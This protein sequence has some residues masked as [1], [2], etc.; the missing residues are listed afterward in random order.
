MVKKGKMDKIIKIFFCLVVFIMFSCTKNEEFQDVN[1]GTNKITNLKNYKLKY[2][3]VNDSISNI[4]G[5]NKECIIKGYLLY[6]KKY[7]EWHVVMA[8]DS[9]ERII[10]IDFL[11]FKN[12]EFVNQYRLYDDN[13]KID[14]KRS[15]FYKN[16]FD[17]KLYQIHFNLPY[18][19]V[20]KTHNSKFT[21]FIVSKGNIIE[22]KTFNSKSDISKGLDFKIDLRNRPK[23]EVVKGVL[24]DYSEKIIGDSI[25]LGANQV[26]TEFYP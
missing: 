22:T 23:V 3:K 5:K 7:G 20:S 19:D 18:D 11:V 9:T 26:Y 21:Y 10:D 17:D 2:S 4:Y 14:L 1:E 6:G 16:K 12:K 13:N 25:N 8:K 15:K 24:I